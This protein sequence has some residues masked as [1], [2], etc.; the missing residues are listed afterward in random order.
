MGVCGEMGGGKERQT[1]SGSE[2]GI[3]N[4]V[5][6]LDLQQIIYFYI[7]IKKEVTKKNVYP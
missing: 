6:L 7:K 1:D 4:G 5:F 3:V 2:K